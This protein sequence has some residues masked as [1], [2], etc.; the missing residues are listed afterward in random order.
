MVVM[1]MGKVKETLAMV[2]DYVWRKKMTT[3]SGFFSGKS[4]STQETWQATNPWTWKI[5]VTGIALML[6]RWCRSPVYSRGICMN[7]EVKLHKR[8]LLLVPFPL[9]EILPEELNWHLF[10]CIGGWLFYTE[11]QEASHKGRPKTFVQ[12]IPQ[13]NSFRIICLKV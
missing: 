9:Q 5:A 6:S 4:H 13:L 7:L 11:R 8:L 3:H 2:W 10:V 12:H 1:M